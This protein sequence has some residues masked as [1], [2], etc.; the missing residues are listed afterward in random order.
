MLLF[1]RLLCQSQCAINHVRYMCLNCVFVL[2][3]SLCCFIGI[4]IIIICSYYYRWLVVVVIRLQN[5][6][7]SWT[8]FGSLF[9]VL[10]VASLVG[11]DGLCNFNGVVG[12]ILLCN[13]VLEVKVRKMDKT[14]IVLFV[15]RCIIERCN[16]ICNM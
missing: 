6:Q 4:Y 3:S 1:S 9:Y 7:K 5:P 10:V 11:L 15:Y 8:Y 14:A 13:C 16:Y 12:L 2:V